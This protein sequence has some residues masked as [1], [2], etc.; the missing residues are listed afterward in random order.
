LSNCLVHLLVLIVPLVLVLVLDQYIV[1]LD[2]TL[3]FINCM[4]LVIMFMV[5]F[6]YI[7]S[8]V[9]L[10]LYLNTCSYSAHSSDRG[11]SDRCNVGVVLR[12]YLSANARYRPGWKSV[13]RGGD[14]SVESFVARAPSIGQV[15]LPL[16][17]G[18]ELL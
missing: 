10:Y 8:I 6:G 18:E 7:S 9:R 2:M 14:S 11:V 16:V 4:L 13:D 3:I 17:L 1:L 15:G 5:C 12:L